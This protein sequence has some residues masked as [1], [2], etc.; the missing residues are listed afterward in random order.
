M[1]LG[2][3]PDHEEGLMLRRGA[4][5]SIV[6]LAAARRR[7]AVR[8]HPREPGHDRRADRHP[9]GR[10]RCRGPRADA[11][12]HRPLRNARQGAV[13]LP[14]EVVIQRA[15]TFT[16]YAGRFLYVEAHTKAATPTS[17]PAMMLTFAGADGV[18]GAP[19]EM[20]ILRD[21]DPALR[22][23]QPYM[24]HRSGAG[25]LRRAQ[26]RARRAADGDD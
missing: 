21:P 13:G 12:T 1:N 22:P 7:R 23:A 5:R 24:Y 20:P 19:A 14:G 17:S 16:N 26:D 15:Y 18:Y 3:S 10:A 11:R 2:D 9:R 25:D 4:V 8:P 6:A